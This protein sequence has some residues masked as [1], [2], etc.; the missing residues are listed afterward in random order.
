MLGINKVCLNRTLS[1]LDNKHERFR[2]YSNMFTKS[3]GLGA[4]FNVY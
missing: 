2:F 4:Y 3:I 1:K